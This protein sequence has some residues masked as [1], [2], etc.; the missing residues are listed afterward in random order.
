MGYSAIITDYIELQENDPLTYPRVA[1]L[2]EAWPKYSIGPAT[3]VTLP[4][5]HYEELDPATGITF[6]YQVNPADP[7]MPGITDV[8]PDIISSAYQIPGT[9]VF[10]ILKL[11]V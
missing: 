7:F 4:A 8:T 6:F 1:I 2:D 11:L 3:P 9:F 10:L 5:T